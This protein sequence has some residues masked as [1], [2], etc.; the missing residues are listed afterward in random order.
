[1]LAMAANGDSGARESEAGE[2]ELGFTIPGECEE[3][4]FSLASSREKSLLKEV[5]T[6]GGPIW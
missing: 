2:E 1:M 5:A 4:R 6:E 3:A